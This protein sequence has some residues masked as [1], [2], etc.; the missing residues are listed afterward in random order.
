MVMH[1][2]VLNLLCCVVAVVSEQLAL[3]T[4]S[5]QVVELQETIAVVSAKVCCDDVEIM[6]N[7]WSHAVLVLLNIMRCVV[8]QLVVSVGTSQGEDRIKS[9]GILKRASERL[10]CCERR[11]LASP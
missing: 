4:S 1:N 6:I 10:D 9:I 2:C 8:V 3:I 5:V 7:Y 11:W